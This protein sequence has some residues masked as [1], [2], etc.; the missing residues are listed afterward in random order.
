MSDAVVIGLHDR[1]DPTTYP[2]HT[3]GTGDPITRRDVDSC[4]NRMDALGDVRE[5]AYSRDVI[6]AWVDGEI[7]ELATCRDAETAR[8]LA[9]LL[10]NHQA[11]LQRVRV[12]LHPDKAEG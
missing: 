7:V 12:P 5:F 10:N 11:L 1:S 4:R 3:Y 6:A 2:A 8:I 9:T